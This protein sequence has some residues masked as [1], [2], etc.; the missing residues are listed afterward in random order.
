MTQI[1]E[2]Q[3]ATLYDRLGGADGIAA[4]VEDILTAHMENPAIRARFLPYQD[5]PEYLATL[6]QHLCDF[7]ALGSGGPAE[8]KGRGMAEAHRGMNISDEEYMAAMD[9]IMA[10][11]ARHEIDETSQKDV[12]AIVYSLKGQI[13]RL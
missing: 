9:D 11:L 2:P 10:V 3:T 1:H 7:M 13:A 12:L 5:D 8:Y 4:L 6:K